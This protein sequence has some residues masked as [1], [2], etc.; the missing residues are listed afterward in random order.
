MKRI[1]AGGLGILAAVALVVTTVT[2]VAAQNTNPRFGK[3]KIKSEDPAPA[4][5]IITKTTAAVSTSLNG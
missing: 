2:P 4:S 1:L 3:W 5:N